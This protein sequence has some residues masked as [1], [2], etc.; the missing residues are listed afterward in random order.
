[1]RVSVLQVAETSKGKER[2]TDS[3]PARKIYLVFNQFIFVFIRS[4]GKHQITAVIHA[5]TGNIM[6]AIIKNHIVPMMV[7]VRGRAELY[8]RVLSDITME[9][10]CHVIIEY[11]RIRTRMHTNYCLFKFIAS[12]RYFLLHESEIGNRL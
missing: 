8:A 10:F 3:T 1:M 7:G 4:Y 6:Y 9:Y 11:I 5:V 2:S 12:V